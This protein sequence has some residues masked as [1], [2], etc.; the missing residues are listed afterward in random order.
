MPDHRLSPVQEVH[1]IVTLGEFNPMIF[2]PAWFAANNLL[3]EEETDKAEGLIVTRELATFVV[4]DIHF[5]VEQGRFG[6]TTKNPRSG[7]PSARLGGRLL[8]TT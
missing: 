8:Q 1:A 6:L 4:S 2:H 3:P 5:Q 7:S